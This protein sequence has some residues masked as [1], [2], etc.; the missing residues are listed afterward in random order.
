MEKMV[1]RIFQNE[2]QKQCEYAINS[3]MYMNDSLNDL[4]K[5]HSGEQLWYFAQNFLTST[6]NVSKLL[7]GS[8]EEIKGSRKP[9]R[10]S[11]QI[12]DQSLVKSR[13]MRN[14]FEHYDERIESWASSSQRRN[15]VDSNIGPRNMIGGIDPSDFLRNFDTDLMAITFKGDTYEIQPIIDELVELRDIA[16]KESNKSHW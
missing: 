13:A 5:E 16:E 2:I 7:W 12:S 14:H 4:Q 9:L 11:L 1:F 8:K 15:Y 6:A 3:A 10:D